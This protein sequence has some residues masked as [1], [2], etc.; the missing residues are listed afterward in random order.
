VCILREA[1]FLRLLSAAESLSSLVRLQT[2]ATFTKSESA[3]AP[4]KRKLIF[5][6]FQHSE[7]LIKAFQMQLVKRSSLSVAAKNGRVAYWRLAILLHV[8]VRQ[9]NCIEWFCVS[10][11]IIAN[12]LQSSSMHVLAL[13]VRVIIV[14]ML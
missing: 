1:S 2:V 10:N 7:R 5:S 13:V 14:F 11:Q 3:A 4:A 12:S 8:D 9:T 6:F